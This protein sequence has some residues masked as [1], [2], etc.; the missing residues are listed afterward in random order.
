MKDE[1]GTNFGAFDLR[2]LADRTDVVTF[3]TT[4]FD[5]DPIDVAPDG[6]AFNLESAGH[7]VIRAS[8]RDKAVERKLLRPGQVV[9]LTFDNLLTGNT[10]KRGHRLRVYLMGSWFPTYSRNLQS[11]ALETTSAEM[12][13]GSIGVLYGPSHPSR[14]VLPII[15]R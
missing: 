1:F 11:G 15:P 5:R 8:H 3:E 13:K 14:L 7:E 2:T 9:K 12:R 10:F 6:T 4:P